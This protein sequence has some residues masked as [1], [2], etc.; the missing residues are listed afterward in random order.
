MRVAALPAAIPGDGLRADCSG[1]SAALRLANPGRRAEEPMPARI[2]RPIFAV[3]LLALAAACAPRN[4]LKKP[5]PPLGRF[6]LGVHAVITDNMQK[7]AVSRG[8]TGEEWQAALNKAIVDRFGRYDGDTY[9]D[10][11]IT[12]DG[13]AL[14]PP[15][16]PVV[17]SPKSVLVLQVVV[18]YDAKQQILDP[19]PKR[20]VVL[21]GTSPATIIGSGLTRTKAQQMQVLSYN[22]A[23]QIQDW[24]LKHPEWFPMTGEPVPDKAPEAKPAAKPAKPAAKGGA[25][26]TSLV[27][28]PPAN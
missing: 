2:A 3:L 24:L 16:L 13:Y 23:K 10:M 18:F 7:G 8:A 25:V 6:L 1:P 15:G 14:A 27:P 21:E 11:A 4:D 5:P 20:F 12:V 17:L 19:K 22:A 26:T 28:K 9:Y